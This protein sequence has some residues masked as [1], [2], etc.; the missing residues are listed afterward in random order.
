MKMRQVDINSKLKEY[1]E[2]KAIELNNEIK[3][4]EVKK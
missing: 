2:I 1:D 4:V 3:K